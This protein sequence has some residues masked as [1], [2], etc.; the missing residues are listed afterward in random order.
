MLQIYPLYIIAKV[1]VLL[2]MFY[3]GLATQLFYKGLAMTIR[4]FGGK[5]GSVVA[6]MR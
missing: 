2:Y 5:G 6:Y 1:R 4:N 3:K